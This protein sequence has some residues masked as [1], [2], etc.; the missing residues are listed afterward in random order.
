MAEENPKKMT[1]EEFFEWQQRQD[2]NYELVDGVPVLT[3]KAMTGASDRHDTVTVNAIS[4]LHQALR[5]KPC[6]PRTDDRSVRTFRG[7][8]RP[9]LLIECGKPDPGSMEAAE[10]RIVFEVLSPSTTR[11]DRFQKLEEYK[12]H[13]HIQ[14]ILLIDTESPRVTVWRRDGSEWHNREETGL[15][16]VIELPEVEVVLPL[17]ALYLDLSFDKAEG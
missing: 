17:S 2:R 11:Y 12:L 14:V 4:F 3:V 6:K 5:G 16:T 9:D 13:P 15:G 1:V 10:P 8:R 7:T